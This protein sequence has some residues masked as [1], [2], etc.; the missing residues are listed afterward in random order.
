M[1]CFLLSD[2]CN[3]PKQQI[4]WEW[5]KWLALAKGALQMSVCIPFVN[6]VF[7]LVPLSFW[8]HIIQNKTVQKNHNDFQV[9]VL[10]FTEWIQENENGWLAWI[11][12]SLHFPHHSSERRECVWNAEMT[13][14]IAHSS[15][16]PVHVSS[17]NISSKLAS[18]CSFT[19]PSGAARSHFPSTF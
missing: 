2:G 1:I 14:R 16:V 5:R 10:C 9:S 11:A 13:T 4:P 7:A 6:P 18:S 3:R 19:F 15:W 17:Q 12:P 8:S